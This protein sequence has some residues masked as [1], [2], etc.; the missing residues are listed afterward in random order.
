MHSSKHHVLAFMSDCCSANIAAYNNSLKKAYPYADFNGCLPHTGNHLGQHV[1]TSNVN[2]FMLLYNAC[3][4]HSPLAQRL[5]RDITG[6]M[7]LRCSKTR[8]FSISDVQ[9]KSLLLNA[10]NGNL[11][12]WVDALRQVYACPTIAPKMQEFFNKS[13]HKLRMFQLELTELV[14]RCGGSP[15]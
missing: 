7:P 4:G 5:I 10:L 2:E 1:E 8:W 13:P 9:E 3:V 12:T 14:H 15:L 6:K 11:R